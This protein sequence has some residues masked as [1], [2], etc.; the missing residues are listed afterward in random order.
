MELRG[1]PVPPIHVAA[2]QSPLE[3]AHVVNS[4]FAP[5]RP[6]FVLLGTIEPR[7]NPL[8]ILNIW[9]ELARPRHS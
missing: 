5:P 6:Y 3:T 7:K 1:E 2:L 8:L 9:R 4:S